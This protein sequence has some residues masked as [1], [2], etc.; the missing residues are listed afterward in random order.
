[1]SVKDDN[2]R[3]AFLEELYKRSGRTNS[4]Y[5]GLYKKWAEGNPEE[6]PNPVR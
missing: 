1:M 5:T 4:L 2:D 6:P 3:Q